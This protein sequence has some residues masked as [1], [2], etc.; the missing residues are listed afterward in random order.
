MS[1]ALRKTVIVSNVDISTYSHEIWPECVKYMDMK[2]RKNLSPKTFPSGSYWRYP[3][4][5]VTLYPPILDR[6]KDLCKC[7]LKFAKFE[8][9]NI[10]LWSSHEKSTYLRFRAWFDR[11]L[12]FSS[13]V[14]F[15]REQFE[16]TE[17]I[18]LS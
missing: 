8:K 12:F 2:S 13:V 9:S 17:T 18:Y 7:P 3:I 16:K 15:F 11:G 5:G 1:T 10:F 4:R 6:V 14:Y